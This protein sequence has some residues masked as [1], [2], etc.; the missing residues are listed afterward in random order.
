MRFV[1]EYS[2]PEYD[3]KVLCQ[4]LPVANFF[5]QAVALGAPA[6]A[7][8]NWIMTDLLRLLGQT[9]KVVTETPLTAASFAALLKLVADQTINMPVAKELFGELFEKGGDPAAMV[10]ARGLG[11]V[12][13]AGAIDAFARQVVAANPKVV[14]DFKGGKKQALQFLVGQ[15]MKL[16]KGKANPAMAGEAI[17]KAIAEG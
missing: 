10:K 12:S 8:S 14:E 6:K 7:A 11:Q 1:E 5:E 2:I 16:S 17:A 13:D 15:V 4:Q 3:A 9:E